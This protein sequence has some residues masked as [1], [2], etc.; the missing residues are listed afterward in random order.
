[1][2][3]QL[4]QNKVSHILKDASVWDMTNQ[5]PATAAVAA[6]QTCI[7]LFASLLLIWLYI[8]NYAVLS[9]TYNHNMDTIGRPILRITH[10]SGN[11]SVQ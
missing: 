3:K 1:M 6:A 7:H 10:R 8:S 2:L 9:S 4:Y 5:K 11:V